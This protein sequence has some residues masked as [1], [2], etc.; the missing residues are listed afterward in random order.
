MSTVTSP[1]IRASLLRV[2]AMPT[3]VADEI[4]ATRSDGY[5]NVVRVV[6]DDEGGAPCRHCLRKSLPGETMLLCSYKPFARATAYQ[7]IGPIFVHADRCE[8]HDEELGF[9]SDFDG[10]RLILRAYDERDDIYDV[11]RYAEPG[12]A[13]SIALEMLANPAV[14][15][16][17]ARSAGRGCFLFRIERA[18]R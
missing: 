18:A 10:N 15:Y 8:R 12:T 1:P 16:V 2:T 7:E 17:H 5:G 14:A 9:P 4:R 3:R 13:E 6:V 11:Q